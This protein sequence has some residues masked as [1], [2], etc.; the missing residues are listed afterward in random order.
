[1]LFH[2]L[3]CWCELKNKSLDCAFIYRLHAGGVDVLHDVNI[4]NV[5]A[6]TLTTGGLHV[7]RVGQNT[8]IHIW[9]F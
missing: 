4:M 7:P 9:V 1:M 6:S 8:Q 3:V 2:Q 5:N